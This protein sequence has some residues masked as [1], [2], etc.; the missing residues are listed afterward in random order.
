MIW[1]PGGVVWSYCNLHFPVF[2]FHPQ[3]SLQAATSRKTCRAAPLCVK[4]AG[5]AA[6]WWP[7]AS[8]ARTPD[9]TTASVR[10]DTTARVCST[11]AQVGQMDVC[12]VPATFQAPR[13]FLSC[14]SKLSDQLVF[15]SLLSVYILMAKSSDVMVK[16]IW[17]ALWVCQHVRRE[18]ISSVNR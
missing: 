11:S 17:R 10:R 7:A 4:Q 18:N 8:A 14:V 13:L 2:V 3:T 12:Q 5:I 9:S 1:W 16:I 6:T 15:S